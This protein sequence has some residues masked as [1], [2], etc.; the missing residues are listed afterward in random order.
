MRRANRFHTASNRKRMPGFFWPLIASLCLAAG[1]AVAQRGTVL[2]QDP[3]GNEVKRYAASYALLV[4]VSDYMAGWPDL[5]SVPRELA[6]VERVLTAQGFQVTTVLNPDA[7][8]LERAFK[9][10]IDAYGYSRDNRLLFFFSGHGHTW[11]EEGH[12]YLVPTDAPRPQTDTGDP[13]PDFLRKALFMSDILAWSKQM[14]AKHALFLFDSCF[15]G[16]VFKERSLPGQPPHISRAIARPVREFI[17]AG[18]AGETVPARSV[19]TPAFVDALEYREG[20]LNGDGY[21]TGIELGLHLEATVPR[22]ARQ[23]PQ[24][25]KH[26]EYRLSRGDFVF[27][28]GHDGQ[29]DADALEPVV[30]VPADQ[31]RRQAPPPVRAQPPQPAD[32]SAGEASLGLSV[33]DRRAVQ[34]ALNGLGFDAGAA[35]GV[36]GPRTRRALAA[37]QRAEGLPATGYLGDGQPERLAAALAEQ[38]PAAPAAPRAGATWTRAGHR[39]GIRLGARGLLSDGQRQRRRGG[40]RTAGA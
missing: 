15:S 25:G 12:G 32:P 16:A 31:T 2:V 3:A 5:E 13:G 30:Q 4:G 17:T 10:F 34:T 8:A 36:L 27:V 29:P 23:S 18:S 40:G 26:P 6:K 1:P 7:D 11:E 38:T 21:I 24:F 33:A 19:F 39:H 37:Y 28:V 35:D 22:H 20:D 9:Q 14:T